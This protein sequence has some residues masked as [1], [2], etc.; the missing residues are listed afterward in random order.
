MK[1]IFA[2]VD[3]N[4]F[5][6]SCERVFRPDLANRPIVV[7]SNNDGCVVAR[8]SEAKAIGIPMGAPL[9]QLKT[10]IQKHRV[11][12]FSSNYELYADM[13]SRM[14]QSIASLVPQIEV[15]SIDECFADLSGMNHLNEL[16][17]QIRDRVLQWVRIPTCVGIGSSKVLAKLANHIAKKNDQCSGVCNLV[18]MTEAALSAL[19]SRIEVGDVWGIGRQLSAKLNASGIQTAQDLRCADHAMLLAKFGIVV[20]RISREL[21]GHSCLTLETT[22]PPKKQ[23]VRSRSFGEMVIDLPNLQAAVSNH[24]A[25]AAEALRAQDSVAGLLTVYIRTN[26]FR[27]TDPQYSGHLSMGFSPATSDTLL[28]NQA[29]QSLLKRIYRAG[30][31]YKKAGVALAAIEPAQ[32]IQT[33]MFQIESSPTRQQL[34]ATLDQLNQRFGRGTVGVATSIQAKNWQMNRQR[35]SPCYTT[36]L[37]DLVV[38]N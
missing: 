36:R 25:S 35:L 8:S 10:L 5:Y 21:D 37:S 29:A 7:L 22:P 24:I 6:A 16:G 2:L 32:T 15:Y 20:E 14:M 13:S 12:V 11:V 19:L 28:L 27:E 34:M 1:P 30:Y 4:S 3:G 33:D 9:F 26:Y 17:H 18:E 23:I 31:A 38:V